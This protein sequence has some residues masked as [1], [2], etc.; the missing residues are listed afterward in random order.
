M[1]RIT[2][3]FGESDVDRLLNKIINDP[4]K[5][6]LIKL[7][8]PMICESHRGSEWFIKLMTG[9]TLPNVFPNGTLCYIHVKNLGYSAN[10]DAIAESDLPTIDGK[11][12]C[13]VKAFRGYHNYNTYDIEFT[14]I[15]T[16]NL[17][18]FK[19]TCSVDSIYLEEFEEF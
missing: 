1:N 17:K 4:N 2:V 5:E 13:K 8:S 12:L 16:D 10:R 15:S 19:D 18:K 3:A 11:I 7:L 14:N 6:D 9:L